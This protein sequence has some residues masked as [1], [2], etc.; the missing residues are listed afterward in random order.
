MTPAEF[1]VRLMQCLD[2]RRDP[3]LDAELAQHLAAEPE[4]AMRVADLLAR[5]EV[6]ALDGTPRIDA[7]ARPRAMRRVSLRFCAVALLAVVASAVWVTRATEPEAQGNEAQ[8]RVL[9]ASL[10]TAVERPLAATVTVRTVLARE[11]GLQFQTFEKRA[12]RR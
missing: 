11:R 3:F 7:A 2:E 4:A 9:R 12:V 8:G 10:S 5:L 1:E 6:V